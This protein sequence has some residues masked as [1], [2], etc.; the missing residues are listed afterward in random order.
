MAKESVRNFLM[1]QGRNLILSLL[2][3]ILVALAALAAVY[4]SKPQEKLSNGGELIEYRQIGPSDHGVLEDYHEV[5]KYSHL[6]VFTKAYPENGAAIIT[7]YG[8]QDN[9]RIAETKRLEAE[10]SSWSKWER[11]IS[12]S[13]IRVIVDRT[14]QADAATK[15]DVLIY[16]TP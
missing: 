9:G 16:L 3:G 11:K 4:F 1:G 15:V 2:G 10:S 7:I 6:A 5:G 13:S 8:C 12:F 14:A